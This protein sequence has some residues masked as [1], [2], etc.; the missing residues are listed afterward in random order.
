[1]ATPMRDPRPVDNWWF[2]T[3]DVAGRIYEFREADGVT[4]AD[5]S[6]RSFTAT[7]RLGSTASTGEV[8]TFDSAVDVNTSRLTIS[9]DNTSIPVGEYVFQLREDSGTFPHV[10]MVGTIQVLR[11][12]AQ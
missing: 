7:M 12:I 1:M 11:G 2:T 10:I 9:L 8:V 6:G 4:L 3:G 5:L